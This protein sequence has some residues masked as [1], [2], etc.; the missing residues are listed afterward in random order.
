MTN[1][2]GEQPARTKLKELVEAG[3][4]RVYGSQS[5]AEAALG[6]R[7]FPAP[8]GDIEKLGPD[9]AAKHR[10]IQDLRRNG[11]SACAGIPERQVLPRFDEHAADLAQASLNGDA[12]TL[13]LDFEHVFMTA[14]AAATEARYNC[15]LAETPL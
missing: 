11:V 5:E 13:V 4:G 8:L 9:G 12:E 15:C 7:C 1:D 14:P 6:S 2:Q 10:L 3:F